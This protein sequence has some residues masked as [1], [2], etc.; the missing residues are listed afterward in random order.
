MPPN[1]INLSIREYLSYRKPSTLSTLLLS[2]FPSWITLIICLHLSLTSLPAARPVKMSSA[3]VDA[4][5]L[6]KTLENL[7][8]SLEA[9]PSSYQDETHRKLGDVAR[10]LSFALESPNDAIHRISISVKPDQLATL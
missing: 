5:A 9:N 8:S 6:T 7:L 4:A 1:T 10:K 3:P 2:T